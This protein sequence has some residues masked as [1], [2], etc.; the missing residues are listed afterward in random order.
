MKRLRKHPR[1]DT[2]GNQQRAG[3]VRWGRLIYLSLVTAFG[4]S[5]VYYLAGET[6]VLS[7]DG[8]VLKDRYAI[9]ASYSA[10]VIEVFVKEGDKVKAGTPLLRL[11]SFEMVKE[12]AD[13][14][15]RDGELAIR[16]GQLRG[17]LGVIKTIMPLAER[18]ARDSRNTVARFDTVSA[19][20]LI[21]AL[22]KGDAL[23]GSLQASERVAD[24]GS[25]EEAAKIELDLVE[26]ARLVSG[27]AMDQLTSIYDNGNVRATA[28][29]EV[30][31]KVPIPGQVVSFA[32][33]LMQINGGNAYILAYLPDQYLFGVE[34][35][36][37]VK[38]SGGG[39]SVRAR[40]ETVL[41]V[42]D[43]LP[44]EFQNMF[45][46]RDRSRL[47]RVAL[48]GGQPFAISQKVRVSGCAFGLCW[49]R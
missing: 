39:T 32:D 45:R 25:Q 34:A 26:Q 15:Y 1:I 8:I 18:T 41:G 13:M 6:V 21:S 43:A 24:L 7:A 47:V 40:I 49:V 31:V 2:L 48:D 4:G 27:G 20:G 12:L 38:V 16:E 28:V 11:E 44:A 42:A 9:D 30:G 29:G 46:P 23:R 33:E 14:A 10:K 36:M 22:S 19:K 3:S 5:I 35:G 17:R 37:P